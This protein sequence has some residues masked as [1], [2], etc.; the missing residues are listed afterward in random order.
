MCLWVS[1]AFWKLS[2][3]KTKTPSS[4]LISAL[5]ATHK[6]AK[7]IAKRTFIF[8]CKIRPSHDR[9][10]TDQASNFKWNENCHK[11]TEVAAIAVQT[12]WHYSW[13]D[14]IGW[15]DGDAPLSKR[16]SVLSNCARSRSAYNLLGLCRFFAICAALFLYGA[17]DNY[18]FR[19]LAFRLSAFSSA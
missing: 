2:F 9:L 14:P 6:Y 4:S 11:T 17:A 18:F 3:V 13:V 16:R 8:T 1:R 19:H 12:T 15:R 10:T 5:A 7:Q